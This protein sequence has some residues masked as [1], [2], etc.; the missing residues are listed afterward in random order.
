MQKT[1]KAAT[2]D[3]L[4]VAAFWSLLPEISGKFAPNVSSD[5]GLFYLRCTSGVNCLIKSSGET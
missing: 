4:P 5:W 3:L 2:G 1:K